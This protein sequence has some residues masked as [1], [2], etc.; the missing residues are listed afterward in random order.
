MLE[1][2]GAGVLNDDIFKKVLEEQLHELRHFHIYI[3][4]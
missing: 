2:Q 1:K 3:Y 4:L